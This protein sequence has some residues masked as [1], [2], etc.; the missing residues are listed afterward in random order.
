MDSL[1]WILEYGAEMKMIDTL[2][3]QYVFTISVP[4]LCFCYLIY[5]AYKT[6]NLLIRLR[7]N[8]R[9]Q[10]S[11]VQ[12]HLKK[13]YDLIPALTGSIREYSEHEKELLTE[14]TT[15]RSQWGESKSSNQQMKTSRRLESALSRLLIVH[16]T[17]P[18]IKADRG[19][20]N[21]QKSMRYIENEVL[22]ERKVYNKRVSQYNQ[23]LEEFP[24][25]IIGRIFKFEERDFWRDNNDA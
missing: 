18:R 6:Y 7:M 2:N 13:K 8:V 9:R 1:L 11:H 12:V 10:A 20:N 14:V 21:I 23:K 15:L 25:L 16:E 24:S 19:F 22:K 5:R 3:W 17:Y 4:I